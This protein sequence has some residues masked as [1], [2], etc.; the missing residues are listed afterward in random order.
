MQRRNLSR[1]ILVGAVAL[2]GLSLPATAT[3]TV[4]GT[5]NE[6][7]YGTSVPGTSALATQMI[8]SSF[9]SNQLDAAYGVVENG[10]LYLGFT[11]N[12]Q[13]NGNVLQIFIDDGRAG[14]ENT[15]A[16]VPTT[17]GGLSK[18]NSSVF[19]PGFNATYA[20]EINDSGTSGSVDQYQLI[21]TP[22]AS[23]QG[24]HWTITNGVGSETT[25]SGI[26]VGFNNSA[27]GG[28]TIGDATGAPDDPSA[29]QAVGTGV[30]VGIPLTFLGNPTGNILVMADINGSND[31]GPSNQFL[32]SLE[33]N[34]PSV[35]KG[36]ESAA[37]P[38]FLQAGGTAT[39]GEGFNFASFPDEYFTVPNSTVA[40]GI[41]LP[42]GGGSWGTASNW[43]NNHI[44][45]ASGDAANF[46]SATAGSSI[47][48]D[49]NRTVGS[50]SFNNVSN[51]YSIDPGNDPNNTLIMDNGANQAMIT[52]AGGIHLIT[53]NIQLNSTTLVSGP[54]H[55]DI[56]E[57]LG[58]I[59][60]AGGLT[61]VAS[62]IQG[63][64]FNIFS[65]II[66][67]GTNTYVGPTTIAAGEL[68]L[69]T[70]ASLPTGTSLIMDAPSPHAVL[71]LYGSNATVSS[72]TSGAGVVIMNDGSADSVFTYAGTNGN[73]STFDGDLTDSSGTNNG[74][75]SLVVASGSLTLTG[76]NTYFGTTTINPGATLVFSNAAATGAS[77]YG[78]GNVTNNGSMVVNDNLA[79]GN[80]LY[81]TGTLTVNA[82]MVIVT[83]AFQQGALVNNGTVVIGAS[84]ATVG[85][86]SGTG[87]LEVNSLQIAAG[88]GES[89][90]GSLSINNSLDITNNA[91]VISFGT[92]GDPISTIASYLKNGYDGGKWDGSGIQSSS[93]ATAPGTTIGYADGNTDSNTAAAPGTILV[94]YTWLGDVNLDGVVNAADAAIMTQNMNMTNADWADGDMNYDGVVNGDDLSLLLL[95]EADSGGAAIAVPEPATMGILAAPALLLAAR[96]RRA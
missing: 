28:I 19:S 8:N 41:W 72:I 33:A 80:N 82:N 89:Q 69:Y 50:I 12:F 79:A 32:P 45:D 65:A 90:V 39:S 44:P 35:K 36:P 16:N 83:N 24:P 88:S 71:D 18:M 40:N 42:T 15:L 38:Y 3:I 61:T 23:F 20:L 51:Y 54:D 78:P 34:T 87:T 96:R 93:V 26:E 92:T 84:T 29:A 43:S 70:S 58:N 75:L 81:G 13:N 17:A 85:N 77:L 5:I 74:K 59:S 49:G 48:L 11:G 46:S 10:F 55:G 30:E 76:T 64:N 52:D 25:S 95:G 53:A 2:V 68:Q 62:T 14:G 67:A 6:S 37:N 91:L 21:G 56:V 66:L 57:L 9:G 7:D 86:I 73:P 60:G 47:T 31:S 27:T 63:S 22:T 1:R 4:D 94:R